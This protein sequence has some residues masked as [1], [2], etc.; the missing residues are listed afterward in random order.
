MLA[1]AAM[2]SCSKDSTEVATFSDDLVRIS[3]GIATRASGIEWASGDAI[4]VFACNA[5][6]SETYAENMQHTTSTAGE[7]STFTPATAGDYI[8]YPPVKDIDVYAIYPYDKDA[9]F[10]NY[11]INVT[12]QND[13]TLIDLMYAKETSVA[14]SA[15][16]VAMTFDHMLSQIEVTLKAATNGGFTDTELAAVSVTV[17]GTKL[18]GNF[19]AKSGDVVS[20][21]DTEADIALTTVSNVAT[22][23]VIPQTATP[24]F[25]ITVSGVDYEVKASELTMAS[26]NTYSYSISV[27]KTAAKITG[28]TINPWT[29]NDNGDLD[30]SDYKV[31]DIELSNG[32]YYINTA[33]GLQDFADLVNGGDVDIYGTLINNID[34]STLGDDWNPI[35]NNATL[36]NGIFEGG[37]HIISGINAVASTTSMEVGLFGCTDINAKISNLGVAG[38]TSG[39]FVGGVVGVNKG[40]IT[41]CYNTCSVNGDC[42]GGVAGVNNGTITNCYNMGSISGD[43]VGGVVGSN[44]G[45]ITNCYN[46]SDMSLGGVRTGGVAAINHNA[47]TSCYYD[48]T[49]GISFLGAADSKDDGTNYCGLTTDMMKG[50]AGLEG[51]LLYYFNDTVNWKADT[52]PYINSGYPILSWQVV[53][54]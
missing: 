51:S 37:G 53:N 33:D 39:L 46:T 43:Q 21:P 14:K 16:A 41:N 44:S 26:G 48:E 47:I 40:T 19:S 35:G 5:D 38:S 13:H 36:Y 9:D 8:Y 24:E 54:E 7:S 28:S 27:S 4:S 42:I 29:S 45:T 3:S 30:A 25:T 6:E 15:N 32:V 10:E 31:P 52:E 20:I 2:A 22:F 1:I 34:L 17:S 50:T 18:E 11:T 23:M 49:V 12:S